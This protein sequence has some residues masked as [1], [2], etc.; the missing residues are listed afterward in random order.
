MK[1]DLLKTLKAGDRIQLSGGY[2]MEPLY[3]K[4]PPSVYRTGQ[5]LKFIKGQ[6]ATPAA[7]VKLDYQI[8]GE[9]I[10]GDILILE[11]RYVD[12]NWQDDGLGSVHI[13]LCDFFPDDIEWKNRRQGEWIEAAASWE[14]I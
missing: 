13:E 2:S 9:K 11:P 7:V 12:Q 1:T 5:V 10:E 8:K 3:L 4:D 14:I 6:N